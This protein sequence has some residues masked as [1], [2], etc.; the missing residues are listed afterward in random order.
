M[1]NVLYI[2]QICL[3]G[4]VYPGEQPAIVERALWQR[5]QQQRQ[6]ETRPGVRPRK[7]EALLAGV[8]YC[9]QCGERMRSTYSS[10]QGRRHLYYV[11]RRTKADAKCQQEPVASV[12][13]EP[14]VIEQLKPIL[15][16]I[17][18]RPFSGIRSSA[19]PTIRVPVRSR[20]LWRTPIASPTRYR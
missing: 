2:G 15:G 20:L 17:W 13:L 14:S 1:R 16:P 12:D 8:L 7:V 10:R 9:A 6:V 11:C 4:V 5:V 3:Q 19:S 18:I